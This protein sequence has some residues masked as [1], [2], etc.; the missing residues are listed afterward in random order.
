MCRGTQNYE[1]RKER[2]KDTR[3]H[4]SWLLFSCEM[5]AS[6]PNIYDFWTSIFDQ[7]YFLPIMYS[8]YFST[9]SKRSYRSPVLTCPRSFSRAPPLT[10]FDFYLKLLP[11]ASF[12]ASHPLPHRSVAT[13]PNFYLLS[14]FSFSLFFFFFLYS[15]RS[16]LPVFGT[17]TRSCEA[18]FNTSRNVSGRCKRMADVHCKNNACTNEFS[19]GNCIFV[20]LPGQ[21]ERQIRSG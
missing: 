18:Y 8:I 17:R 21:I 19:N 13:Y 4:V 15:L 3:S 16:H 11:P 7:P 1:V 12:L 9:V 20:E 10:L 14:F 5:A 2:W 6:R